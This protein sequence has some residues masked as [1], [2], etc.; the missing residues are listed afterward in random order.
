VKPRIPGGQPLFNE[1]GERRP[2]LIRKGNRNSFTLEVL[3]HANSP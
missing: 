3:K 1:A 2:D